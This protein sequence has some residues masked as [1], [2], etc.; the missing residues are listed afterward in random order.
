MCLL[1][2]IATGG[3]A[4]GAGA[5]R[6]LVAL[7]GSDLSGRLAQIGA[8]RLHFDFLVDVDLTVLSSCPNVTVRSSAGASVMNATELADGVRDGK[9]YLV[10]VY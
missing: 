2:H 1:D 10:R 4:R 3:I 9:G 7:A 5:L 6:A 8:L